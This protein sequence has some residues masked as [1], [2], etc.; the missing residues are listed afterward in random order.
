MIINYLN[1]EG[2]QTYDNLIKKYIDKH[3]EGQ[4]D[5][6]IVTTA[7][8]DNVQDYVD[9]LIENSI[10]G[11][12]SAK[13]QSLFKEPVFVEKD[14]DL[15]TYID[16]IQENQILVLSNN[17]EYPNELSIINDVYI[18]ANGSTLT[19]IISISADS[20]VTFENATFTNT[21]NF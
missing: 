20:N 3:A 5:Q 15:D 17:S 1:Y 12:E 16:T 9:L 13:I 19:G 10:V 11:I 21:L 2:L 7:V 18:N 6:N 8:I 14:A 4:I